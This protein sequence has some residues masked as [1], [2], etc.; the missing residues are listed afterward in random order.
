MMKSDVPNLYL[1]GAPRSGTSF[2]FSRLGQHPDIYAPPVKEPHFHL[3]TSWAVGGPE[4]EAFTRPLADFQSGKLTSVW[5]GLMRDEDQYRTLYRA[6]RGV[7]W[8]L[9]GTPNYLA[10]GGD[11][12]ARIDQYSGPKARVIAVLRDPVARALSHYQLYRQLGWETLSFVDAVNAAPDRIARGWAPAWDYIAYSLYQ[13]P[14]KQW[15][16]VFGDRLHVLSFEDMATNPDLVSED[17]ATWL[18]LSKTIPA[19]PVPFNQSAT[20][21]GLDYDQAHGALEASGRITIED[22]RRVHRA[23]HNDKY[24]PPLVCVGMPVHN[25]AAT[26]ASSLASLQAQ[27]YSN[28]RITVCDN[29]STDATREIVEQI[30]A[31]DPRVELVG[32]DDLVDIRSSYARA[33]DTAKGGYFMFAPADDHWTPEFIAAAVGR[34]QGNRD[35]AVCCGQIRLFDDDGQTF[36]SDG[37]QSISGSKAYR[38]QRALLTGFD[39]ARLYG[40]IRQSA[41]TRLFPKSAPQGWDLYSAAKLA[42]HG[43]I[44]VLDMIAMH[45]HQ[46]PLGQYQAKLREQE[47]RFWGQVFYGRHIARLFR[48]DPD[49]DT[50]TLGARAALASFVWRQGHL[51]FY[52]HRYWKTTRWLRRISRLFAK[53]NKVAT[54]P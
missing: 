50:S 43:D 48:Q 40:V 45:R 26:I 15:R 49:F 54:R 19:A 22:E 7:Q 27:T 4:A 14:I 23:A 12:A 28:L 46:T 20:I 17:I 16:Q 13:E 9:E 36:L 11:M 52:R 3:S 41:L 30:A 35:I 5:G 25:G 32:F 38:W 29:A 44:A 24:T 42:L 51:A 53:I 34:M 31:K 47:P 2:L 21:D 1:I 8:R 18:G 6:G 39:G 10:A 33:M 37:I